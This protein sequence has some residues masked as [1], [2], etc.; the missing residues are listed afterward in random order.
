MSEA[1]LP[2]LPSRPADGHKGTFGTVCVLGGQG[3]GPRVM[4]GG[5][6]LAALGALRSGAGLAV[7]AVPAPL[8]AAGLT[9]APSA[10]GLALP[11][12]RAGRLDPSGVA[13]LLDRFAADFDCLAVGPGLGDDEP[14]RR[15]MARLVGRDDVPLVIDADGLNALS[16]LADFSRDL[17]APA[18]ITPHPGEYARLAAAL[19]VSADPVGTSSRPAAAQE[20]AR[21]LG[22][23]VVLKGAGTVVSDGIDTWTN[24]SGN[25]ALATAGTGDVL[26]GVIAGLVAQ[27]GAR[28]ALSLYDCARLGVHA[29]GLA[30]DRWAAGRGDAGLLAGDLLDELPQ[31]MAGLRQPATLR[32]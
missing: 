1:A 27:H 7:L 3:A 28:G 2:S 22:C 4:V 30:A 26:T 19:G 24:D 10:T 13:E 11:V 15:V 20:L 14:Q 16:G 5:P 12:D 17:K 6:A 21:R 25:V 31:V 29:H 23:V 8:M 9:I 18:V 32:R